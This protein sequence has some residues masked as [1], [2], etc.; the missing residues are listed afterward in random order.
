MTILFYAYIVYHQ[1]NSISLG[2][3]MNLENK[4]VYY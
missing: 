4:K 1:F 3:V 2:A